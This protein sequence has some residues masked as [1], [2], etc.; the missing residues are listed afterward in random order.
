MAKMQHEDE[1]RPL[2]LHSELTDPPVSQG[3]F[4]SKIVSTEF[5][6][7]LTQVAVGVV[8][9]FVSLGIIDAASSEDMSKNITGIIGAV[10][11]LITNLW[12]VIKYTSS[13]TELKRE[14][15]RMN[16][17]RIVAERSLPAEVSISKSTSTE[18]VK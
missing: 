12:A 10:A 4:F 7:M 1:P 14:T 18:T 8:M 17:D 5:V 3:A 11:A 2:M 6:G 16:V 15:L 13:R 9:M